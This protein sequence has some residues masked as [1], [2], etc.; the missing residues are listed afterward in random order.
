MSVRITK[1]WRHGIIATQ[2]QA[3]VVLIDRA[4]RAAVKSAETQ[5]PIAAG[6][7][8]TLTTVW[9]AFGHDP[10]T[11]FVSPSIEDRVE[12]ARHRLLAAGR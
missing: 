6:H 2:D 10:E 3:S 11:L 4:L 12:A 8:A 9:T 1:G 5:E 7:A